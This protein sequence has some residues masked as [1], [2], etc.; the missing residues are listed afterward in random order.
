VADADA[1]PNPNRIA[2]P[3]AVMKARV[4]CSA[5]VTFSGLATSCG[6]RQPALPESER[7]SVVGATEEIPRP[8]STEEPRV[9]QPGAPEPT[10]MQY[11]FPTPGPDPVSAWRPPP[12]AVPLAIRPE[13]HFYFLRPIP[14][15]NVNWPHPLYRYGNTFFGEE[16]IHTGVDLDAPRGTPVLAAGSG[17]VMTVGYG[18]Y[19]G[20]QNPKDPY[21]LAVSIRH[22][23]GYDGKVL[24]T[25][26]AHLE[27]ARVW[28]GQRVEAGEQIGSVGDTGNADGAHLHFE[29]RL[30]E[31]GYFTTRNPELWMVPPEG[32][33]VLA[34]R[35]MDTIGR[36]LAEQLVQIRSLETNKRWEVWAYALDTV[37][38]D[39]GYG[40]NFVISDL[41]AGPY[42]VEVDYAGHPYTAQLLLKPGQTNFLTFRGRSG[43]QLESTAESARAARPPYP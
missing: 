15:G 16:S 39:D 28:V 42:E 21:G 30:G 6:P 12:Y 40:E 3:H 4:L 27:E 26:Y 31:D 2:D 11:A 23:F 9:G 10:P 38:S 43:F 20:I 13:D 32:W 7:S 33:G 14:S 36:P 35:L 34:G 41:P 8:A 24:Y 17:Q 37:H 22:D 1:Q 25:V 5:L 29:V 18:L 19:S